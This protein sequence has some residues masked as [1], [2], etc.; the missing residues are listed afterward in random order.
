MSTP[1]FR[2]EVPAWSK[3]AELV[4]SDHD[5][6]YEVTIHMGEDGVF[7]LQKR[8]GRR[9][10]AGGGQIKVEPYQSLKGAT[11]NADAIL[12]EKIGKGYVLT[13]RPYSASSRVERAYDM[14]EDY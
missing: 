1:D 14:D 12:G 11:I 10:D 8:W 9:P 6:F 3:Y 13:E 5:K 7:Y 2:D 4:N